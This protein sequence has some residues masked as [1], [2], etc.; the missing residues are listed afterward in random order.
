MPKKILIICAKYRC[1][2]IK[3]NIKYKYINV[4]FGNFLKSM[5]GD[6]MD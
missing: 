1:K 2:N 4:S 6:D 3:L 5:K